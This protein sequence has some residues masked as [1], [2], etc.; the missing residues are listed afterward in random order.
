MTFHSIKV[1]TV[2]SNTTFSIILCLTHFLCMYV[3]LFIIIEIKSYD[4]F[5][6][7]NESV[8]LGLFNFQTWSLEQYTACTRYF[9]TMFE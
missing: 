2:P 1:E 7:D 9:I 8:F 3:L 4:P 6:N 5:T